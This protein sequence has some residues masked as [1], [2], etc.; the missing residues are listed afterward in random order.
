M[1]M[2]IYFQNRKMSFLNFHLQIYAPYNT[3]FHL[4]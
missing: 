3:E 2:N 1:S 4:N